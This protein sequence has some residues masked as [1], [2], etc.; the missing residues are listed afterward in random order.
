MLKRLLFSVVVLSFCTTSAF[1]Q[2]LTED[3]FVT[4]GQGA[5]ASSSATFGQDDTSGTAF[6][7]SQNGFDF[8][9]FDLTFST[10]DASVIN[11]SGA[12][13]FNPAF[14][15]NNRFDGDQVAETTDVTGNLLGVAVTAL[16]VST[17]FTMLDPE[18]DG[19]VGANGAFR[20]AQIDFDI[21]G[22][23]DAD[24][25]LAVGPNAFFSSATPDVLLTPTLGAGSLTVEAAAIPEPSTAGILALG[26]VG[27]VA[28]R[29]RS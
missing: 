3:V 21:V 28:R 11:F 13:V 10:S 5:A 22:G 17:N 26:L 14:I 20:I 4:F 9:A 16:G 24:I 6:V 2:D 1:A 27:F 19:D 18:F 7:F 25:T 12:E 29:R 15:G 8:G 23:G